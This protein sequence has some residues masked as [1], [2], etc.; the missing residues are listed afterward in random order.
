MRAVLHLVLLAQCTA[1]KDEKDK[2]Q[3][4]WEKMLD[5]A[6]SFFDCWILY[7]FVLENGTAYLQESTIL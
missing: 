3:R 6:R 4:T 1:V 2:E 7:D 5:Q